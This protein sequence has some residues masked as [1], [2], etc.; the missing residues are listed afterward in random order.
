MLCN[1]CTA[2]LFQLRQDHHHTTLESLITAKEERCYICAPLWVHVHQK[3]GPPAELLEFPFLF[4]SI[5][6]FDRSTGFVFIVF[7]LVGDERRKGEYACHI[8]TGLEVQAVNDIRERLTEDMLDQGIKKTQ[9]WMAECFKSHVRCQKNTNPTIYPTR[10][11]KLE[12]GRVRL[13]ITAEEEPQGPYIA[14]SYCWGKDPTFLRLEDS[15]C[16]ELK[17]G[18]AISRLPTA[19]QEATCF[20]QNSLW[21][22]SRSA[23]FGSMLYV[24]FKAKLPTKTGSPNVTKCILT[25]ALARAENPHQSCL[26]GGPLGL[27]LPFEVASTEFSSD[28]GK[29]VVYST[30]FY[31]DLLYNQPLWSRAWAMQERILPPRVNH[32][33]RGLDPY[34]DKP[35]ARETDIE[36][37]RKQ[38]ANIVA[39]YTNRKLTCPEKDKLLAISALARRWEVAMQD[40]YIAGHFWSMLSYSLDWAMKANSTRPP[41]RIQVVWKQADDGRSITVP[42]WSWASMDGCQVHSLTKSDRDFVHVQSWRLIPGPTEGT[43]VPALTIL[44]DVADIPQVDGTYRVRDDSCMILIDDPEADDETHECRL[45]RLTST[46]GLIARRGD[47]VTGP[48]YRRVGYFILVGKFGKIIGRREKETVT[49][50]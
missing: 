4:V 19:F 28:S 39:E 40:E 11:L 8:R 5:P 49:L 50:I 25:L 44:A 38:W 12:E 43:L 21:A 46:G 20:I 13:T 24:S 14:L 26:G 15:T 3:F 23:I 45:V 37:L 16:E 17:K 10:L 1:T 18:V 29:C 41:R 2:M 7:D 6:P 48:V 47:S 42:S 22:K 27:V 32:L 36:T 9:R 33:I 35:C 34:S 31:A 30:T